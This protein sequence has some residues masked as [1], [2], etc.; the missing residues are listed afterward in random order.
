MFATGV[1]AGFIIDIIYQSQVALGDPLP[2]LGT[3]GETKANK[4]SVLFFVR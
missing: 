1:S 3:H 4:G 2:S